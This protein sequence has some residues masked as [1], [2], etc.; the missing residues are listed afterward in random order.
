[1]LECFTLCLAL[2]LPSTVA[3]ESC[4][5]T[6]ESGIRSVIS[7]PT[8]WDDGGTTQSPCA[9]APTQMELMFTT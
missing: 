2:K 1:M 9:H 5:A 4:T 7:F 3:Q 8:H 6:G